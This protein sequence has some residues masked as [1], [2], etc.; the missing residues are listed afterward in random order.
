MAAIFPEPEGLRELPMG[1]GTLLPPL[2][3]VEVNFHRRQSYPVTRVSQFL[4]VEPVSEVSESPIYYV[5]KR[6]EKDGKQYVATYY[7]LFYEV[8]PGM[9]KHHTDARM[10]PNIVGC[11]LHAASCA[12]ACAWK[13][14]S[15]SALSFCVAVQAGRRLERIE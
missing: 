8:N 15:C 7:T 14:R 5:Y 2:M 13:P 9:L 10:P 4:K 6:V 11:Q 12:R 1:T 3:P